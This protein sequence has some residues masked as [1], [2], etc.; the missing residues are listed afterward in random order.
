MENN[1]N[2]QNIL[3]K[4]RIGFSSLDVSNN[5]DPKYQIRDP[6]ELTNATLSTDE[7]YNYCFLLRPTFPSQS[8]D[9]F[10]EVVY[11]NENLILEQPNQ[12]DIVSPQNRR[13]DD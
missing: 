2:H 10:L 9:K 7:Q 4:V 6:Y 5:D 13:S 12:L 1:K 3:P 8:S 11:G